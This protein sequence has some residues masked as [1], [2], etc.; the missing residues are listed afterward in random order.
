MNNHDLECSCYELSELDT[1]EQVQA[2]CVIHTDGKS[3]L[4][5]RREEE[6]WKREQILKGR[7]DEQL[8]P[9][10]R[11]GFLI[12]LYYFLFMFGINIQEFSSFTYTDMTCNI[13]SHLLVT[14]SILKSLYWLHCF[15]EYALLNFMSVHLFILLDTS[16]LCLCCCQCHVFLVCI[17]QSG[18]ISMLGRLKVIVV[19]FCCTCNVML[20]LCV[21]CFL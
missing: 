5:E 15:C 6:G 16:L 14:Y 8:F 10:R 18:C 21:S 7:I 17:P 2:S 1:F 19:S 13:L 12:S 9:W 4:E 11:T 3:S 20:L